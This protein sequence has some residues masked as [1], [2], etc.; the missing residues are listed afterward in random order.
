MTTNDTLKIIIVVTISL[1]FLINSVLFGWEAT[2]R[3]AEDVATINNS[4]QII[5][6]DE[7]TSAKIQSCVDGGGL[8]NYHK[9]H[10]V[11]CKKNN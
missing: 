9:G 8:P 10:F 5:N 1:S 3:S 2:R 7:D 6:N 4:K 11:D